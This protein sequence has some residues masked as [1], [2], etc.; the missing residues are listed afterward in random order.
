MPTQYIC[1]MIYT[2]RTSLMSISLSPTPTPSAFSVP[3]GVLT[4]C[5]MIGESWML[6]PAPGGYSSIHTI[7]CTSYVVENR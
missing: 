3:C 1:S 5:R 7:V 6:M 4:A 2:S